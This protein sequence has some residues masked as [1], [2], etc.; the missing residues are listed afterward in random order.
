MKNIIAILA[1][2]SLTAHVY[3]QQVVRRRTPVDMNATV[4]PVSN[5]PVNTNA[6][7]RNN[8]SQE[9]SKVVSPTSTTVIN[10]DGMKR[11]KPE[12]MNNI[13]S[14]KKD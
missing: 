3:A 13:Q 7:K 14:P 10:P 2:M 4:Q 12:S 5:T 11:R 9:L 1:I 8:K 6:V